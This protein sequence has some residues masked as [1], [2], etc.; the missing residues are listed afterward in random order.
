MGDNE[1][2]AQRKKLPV[3]HFKEQFV[4][5][6]RFNQVV[7]VVGETG[8]GKST[9]MPQYLMGKKYNIA[10]FYSVYDIFSLECSNN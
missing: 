2:N 8:S 10:A 9:Q 1:I 7:V 4:N 5:A 3:Y 6:V